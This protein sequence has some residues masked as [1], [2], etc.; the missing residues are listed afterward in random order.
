MLKYLEKGHTYNAADTVHSL[1]ESKTRR[2]NIYSPREWYEK[3]SS[4]KRSKQHP[5]Q[6]VIVEQDIIFDWKDLAEKIHLDK[7][8]SGKA[9]PWSKIRQITATSSS[10]QKFTF[11]VNFDAEQPTSVSTRNV[12]R[13]VKF[14]TY[15]L[16][17]LYAGPLPIAVAKLKDLLFYC[18][19]NHVPVE[20][21]GF[22][23]KLI[24]CESL[25]DA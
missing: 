24:S 7:D 1:I 25:G 22:F 21:Q 18:D 3:I 2:L 10:P 6:L 5:I 15:T 16:K 11:K 17:K 4:A 9:I 23:R 19:N 20:D 8:E 13:P 14:T 12:G